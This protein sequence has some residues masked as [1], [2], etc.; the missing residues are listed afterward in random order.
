MMR[1]F[2]QMPFGVVVTDLQG[3]ITY[4]NRATIELSGYSRQELLGKNPRVF[5]SGNMPRA[6]YRTLYET[7]KSGRVWQADIENRRKDGVLVWERLTVSPMRASDGAITHYIG[8]KEPLSHG[9]RSDEESLSDA[10]RLRTLISKIP[11]G[12]AILRVDGVIEYMNS[13]ALALFGFGPSAPLGKSILDCIPAP[14]NPDV[15]AF[16][17]EEWQDESI[18]RS[19]HRIRGSGVDGK[20][21]QVEGVPIPGHTEGERKMVFFHDITE[22]RHSRRLLTSF[23]ECNRLLLEE[24]N[25][26]DSL[27]TACQILGES[28]MV[29]RV[30]VYQLS[31]GGGQRPWMKTFNQWNQAKQENAS[32]WCEQPFQPALF[33]TIKQTLEAGRE[34]ASETSLLPE[35]LSNVLQSAEIRSILLAPIMVNANLWG[36]FSFEEFGKERSWCSREIVLAQ[37]IAANTGLRMQQDFDE[38]R[39]RQSVVEMEK[40]VRE[41]EAANQSKSNFIAIMSHEIRTPLTGIVGMA[42]I[43]AD[44]PLSEEQRDYTET[45]RSSSNSLLALIND[46]LDLSKIEAGRFEVHNEPFDLHEFLAGFCGLFRPWAQR[47]NLQFDYQPDEGLPHTVEGDHTRLQQIL[48]NLVSNAIKFTE[49][50]HVRLKVDIVSKNQLRCLLRFTVED[51]G[52]GIP[53][54]VRN[55][56]FSTYTQADSSISRRY[57]GTG[58]GLVISKQLTELLGGRIDFESEE[59]LGT[60]FRVEIPFPIIKSPAKPGKPVESGQ[61]V[62]ADKDSLEPVSTPEDIPLLVVEDNPVNQK[63]ILLQLKKLGYQPDLATNGVEAIVKTAEKEYQVILMDCQMPEMDGYEAARQIMDRGKEV[64]E[65]TPYIIALTAAA[66]EGDRERAL[67]SGMRAYLSKPA[68]YQKLKAEIEKGISVW[69]SQQAGF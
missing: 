4:I 35:P 8:L 39:L 36:V 53:E 45:I 50:G 28:F 1:A 13:P 59:G 23:S 38:E 16:Y 22:E 46:V 15:T 68:P 63:V 19:E 11:M 61:P 29:S 60:T 9:R 34:V 56:I 44:T 51:S 57:G 3:T 21:I 17:H 30:A 41:A 24:G 33:A 48:S 49:K 52:M 54:N 25:I 55:R 14:I 58:L 67:Q 37:S 20:T 47:E 62:S 32:V 65:T 10:A 12:M 64:G 18:R 40:A 6:L 66:M 43:L 26:R 7:V 2:D 69:N 27:E 5:K 42:G 31:S